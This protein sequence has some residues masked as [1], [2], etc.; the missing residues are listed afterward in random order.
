MTLPPLPEPSPLLGVFGYDAYDM[1]AYGELCRAQALEEAEKNN[2]GL[3]EANE[4]FGRR[5]AW[6]TERMFE[7]EQR[8]EAAEKDAKRYRWLRG[9]GH[10][11][12]DNELPHAVY[13]T[14]NSWGKW[15]DMLL[16]GSDLDAAIDAAMERT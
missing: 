4:A 8:L 1:R 10:E 12:A 7:M 15:R 13:H 16:E 14:Q 9:A 2:A 11:H 5:Q 3:R 6:W